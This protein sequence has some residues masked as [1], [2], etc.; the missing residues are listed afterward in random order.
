VRWLVVLLVVLT[1]CVPWVDAPGHLSPRTL[2]AGG[3]SEIDAGRAVNYN[4]CWPGQG[5][6]VF[7]AGHRSTH[8][9]VFGP[10]AGL[11]PG[12]TVRVGYDGLV[13]EYQVVSHVIASGDQQVRDVLRGDLVLQTSAPNG[14]VHLIYCTQ[15]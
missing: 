6:T 8:G 10:V 4:G 14:Q 7:L 12:D 15:V 3:Q 5:C 11:E 9:S 1:A 2:V 13:W